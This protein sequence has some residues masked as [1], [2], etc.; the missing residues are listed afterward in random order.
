MGWVHGADHI[1]YHHVASTGQTVIGPS[2][3]ICWKGRSFFSNLVSFCDKITHLVDGEKA[4]NV[5]SWIL[6]RY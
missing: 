1:Q 2:Q 4:V 3:H 5:V 6:A